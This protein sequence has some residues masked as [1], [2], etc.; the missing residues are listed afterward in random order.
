MSSGEGWWDRRAAKLTWRRSSRTPG[1]RSMTSYRSM[2]ICGKFRRPRSKN[3]AGPRRWN[4]R[5]WRVVKGEDLTEQCVCTRNPS[6]ES[7][8]KYM[9][10]VAP[11]LKAIDLERI[12]F[13]VMRRTHASFMRELKVDPK[14]VA[15]QLGHSVD[16]NLNVY[17]KTALSL[18]KEALDV[19]ERVLEQSDSAESPSRMM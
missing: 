14:V 19:F 5:K 4:W 11:R 1:G 8:R 7:K 17:S 12:N 15:D 18:R 6:R 9:P 13:Q 2:T 3:C 16:A 10:V